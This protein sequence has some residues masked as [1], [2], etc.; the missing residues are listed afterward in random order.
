[1]SWKG[2]ECK[3]LEEWSR[4][5]VHWQTTMPFTLEESMFL[6]EILLHGSNQMCMIK[7]FIAEC[8]VYVYNKLFF[9]SSQHFVNQVRKYRSCQKDSWHSKD[10]SFLKGWHSRQ[11]IFFN[12][13]DSAPTG[14]LATRTSKSAS[15][16]C[17]KTLSWRK[18]LRVFGMRHILH[19]PKKSVVVPVT[20]LAWGTW[21]RL[22]CCSLPAFFHKV[23][24]VSLFDWGC[25]PKF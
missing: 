20:M 22:F 13:F 10:N 18:L 6:W 24:K 19:P 8:N 16:K 2:W 1:M 23:I 7:I 5:F 11:S 3:F 15:A 14:A 25:P 4:L 21:I 9:A 12:V 17:F